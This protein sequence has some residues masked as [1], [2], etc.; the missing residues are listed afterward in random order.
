MKE[1]FLEVYSPEGTKTG[2][3]KV[4]LRFIE[5]AYF[6]QLYTYGFSQMKGI[7]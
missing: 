1:E 4:S 6:I 2:Q 3:K 7:Y 5:K